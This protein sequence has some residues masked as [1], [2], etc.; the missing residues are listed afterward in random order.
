MLKN[1]KIRTRMIVSYLI[2]VA[3]LLVCGI[4]SIVMLNSVSQTLEDF[5]NQQFQTVNNAWNARR[6]VISARA[7]VLFNILADTPEEVTTYT[8]A[9]QDDFQTVRSCITEVEKTFAGDK[10]LLTEC[11]TMLDQAEPYLTQIATLCSDLTQASND[12]ALEIMQTSYMP[13]MDQVREDLT[14]VGDIADQNA[15]S[16]VEAGQKL[17]TTADIIIIVLIVVAVII[18]VA[19]AMYMSEGVRRPVQEMMK[20]SADMA[21][22][23]LDT[24]ITY[25]SKDEL[26]EMARSM[27]QLTEAMRGIITDVDHLL[28][29]MGSGNFTV[30]TR[31]E[32]AYVGD[33]RGILE[34]ARTLRDTMNDTLTQIDVSADQVNSGGE[35]VS[36]GAQA[37]AQGATEQA[38][39]VQELAATIN[40]IA[41]QVKSTAQLAGQAE[42]D[43]R[44]AGDEIQ[45]C[46]A[47]MNDLMAAM[48]MINDKSKEISKVVKTI[49]DIAFQTNILA[50]NAAVEAARAGSAGK[51]FAVVAD[52][53]RNL[54]TKSQEAAKSTTTLIEETVRAVENGSQL[55]VET[56]K[57]LQAVVEDAEKVLS[58]VTSISGA[59]A[60]QSDAVAQVTTGIDQISSVVQTN[61]ATAEQSAAASEQLSAQAKLLKDLVGKFT[62]SQEGPKVMSGVSHSS[63]GSDY[64]YAGGSYSGGDKY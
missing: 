57:A 64:D 14:T 12:R 28:S 49:E 53:V 63:S 44:R 60:D 10:S 42:E 3:L 40:G 61:S 11:E 15:R 30:R 25:E 59:T 32:A 31:N 54:A 7:N 2:I 8:K 21:A 5:Y 20:A 27:K 48:Q 18:S 62:L 19:L 50:L 24:N 47:H 39:S 51:G 29:E 58:A 6:T 26:G 52:E 38:A 22:G 13:L 36:S 56:E 1:M 37:L 9:A 55:S 33:F 4:T 17:A 35:Q 16:K 45:Q 46:S 34:S 43:D 41:D 23:K